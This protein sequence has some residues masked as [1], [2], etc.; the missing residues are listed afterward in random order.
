MPGTQK[1]S[2]SLNKHVI[3]TTAERIRMGLTGVALRNLNIY[4]TLQ[5]LEASGRL[6]YTGVYGLLTVTIERT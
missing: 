1:L 5:K 6:E 4:K 3:K 2:V